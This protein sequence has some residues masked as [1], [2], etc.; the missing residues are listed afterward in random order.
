[1]EIPNPPQYERVSS[2]FGQRYDITEMGSAILPTAPFEISTP[3]TECTSLP[4]PHE[5]AALPAPDLSLLMSNLD[6]RETGH[7]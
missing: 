6:V 7:C 2:R 4:V 3:D 5:T 1:M